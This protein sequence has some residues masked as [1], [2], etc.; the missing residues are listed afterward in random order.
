SQGATTSSTPA[1]TTVEITS[2]LGATESPKLETANAIT[3][4]ATSNSPISAR[5]SS[6][7]A[8]QSTLPLDHTSKMPKIETATGHTPSWTMP[9]AWVRSAASASPSTIDDAPSA[10][11]AGVAP[12]G[13]AT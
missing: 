2:A 8:D 12:L 5:T 9:T 4:T 3:P 13:T 11:P 1:S 7:G 10:R 6:A